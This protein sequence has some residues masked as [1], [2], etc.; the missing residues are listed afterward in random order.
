MMVL[1]GQPYFLFISREK[2]VNGCLSV[3]RTGRVLHISGT[4]F[5][6]FFVR[7]WMG[8]RVWYISKHKGRTKIN[9]SVGLYEVV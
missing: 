6:F 1:V 7:V 4:F 9:R 2:N 5:F 3:G 8:E